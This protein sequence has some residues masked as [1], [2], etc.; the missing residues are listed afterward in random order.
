VSLIFNGR[1]RIQ[2]GACCDPLRKQVQACGLSIDPGQVD[3]LQG[4][5]DA[6]VKLSVQHILS[7][8]EQHKANQRLMKR[9]ASAVSASPGA[10][11][12]TV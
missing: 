1:L 4:Y 11:K 10:D 6:I 9:I 8:G 12:G 7:D 5:A 3:A 2:F